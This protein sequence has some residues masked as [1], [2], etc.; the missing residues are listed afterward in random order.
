MRF[1]VDE[2]LPIGLARWIGEQGHISE[3]VTEVGLS[4]ASDAA[5]ARHA[6]DVDAIIV[7]KDEDFIAAVIRGS[8][9]RVLWL[10]VGNLRNPALIATMTISWPEMVDR[11]AAGERLVE[12]RPPQAGMRSSTSVGSRST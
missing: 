6:V 11:F 10:R 3:H 4:G 12:V 7:T 1:L 8:A 2:Q 5:I 9:A